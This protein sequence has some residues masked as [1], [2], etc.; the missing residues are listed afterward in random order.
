[1]DELEKLGWER[2]EDKK[3]IEYRKYN[4]ERVIYGLEYPT[5]YIFINKRYK[6]VK[7]MYEHSNEVILTKK[8]V[9]ALA[10]ILSELK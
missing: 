6:S 1:M 4:V 2:E 10:E 7:M 9:L 8:E 3:Y 5:L